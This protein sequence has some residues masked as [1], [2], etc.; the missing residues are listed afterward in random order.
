MDGNGHRKRI[1]EDEIR[2][3]LFT[4]RARYEMT[5]SQVDPARLNERRQKNK[6]AAEKSRKKK[7]ELFAKLLTEN[8]QL[9]QDKCQL[10]AMIEKL[11]ADL[12]KLTK[13]NGGLRYNI[14]HLKRWIGKHAKDLG[15]GK[16]LQKRQ[17]ADGKKRLAKA[18]DSSSK[19]VLRGDPSLHGAA[20]VVADDDQD[21]DQDQRLSG[22][23]SPPLSSVSEFQDQRL[24]SVSPPLPSDSKLLS[25]YPITASPSPPP[26]SQFS[27]VPILRQQV[28]SKCSSPQP[29]SQDIF[30]PVGTRTVR[31]ALPHLPEDHHSSQTVQQP[32]RTSAV[33]SLPPVPVSQVAEQLQEDQHRETLQHPL[34][35]RTVVT[36]PQLPGDDHSSETGPPEEVV[37]AGGQQLVYFPKDTVFIVHD[38]EGGQVI[39]M[40]PDVQQEVT[41]D[42]QEALHTTATTQHVLQLSERIKDVQEANPEAPEVEEPSVEATEVQRASVEASEVQDARETTT[43][44]Q[45]VPQ[46]TVEVSQMQTVTDNITTED[47]H[48]DLI[49]NGA[50]ANETE[51]RQETT[52]TVPDNN[53]VYQPSVASSIEVLLKLGYRIQLPEGS[54]LL[55]NTEEQI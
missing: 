47:L 6:E 31:F 45:Q 40:A 4:K 52:L 36:L 37:Y 21:Q 5:D 27:L 54:Q 24:S 53:T 25:S 28:A 2:S 23:A 35:T 34:G 43:E 19:G 29:P 9:Q 1:S 49:K 17:Q 20:V 14:D 26:S 11:K 22:S 30:Q 55:S 51:P 8:D 50:A 48:D 41:L 46:A 13:E 7:K 10:V 3:D 15:L 32:E 38:E 16:H 39:M 33:I 12:N 42:A 44:A 18:T